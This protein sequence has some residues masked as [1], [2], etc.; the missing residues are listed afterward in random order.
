MI[1]GAE[2]FFF[3]VAAQG[4]HVRVLAEEQDVWDVA[5]FAGFDELILERAG[6]GVGQEACVHLPADFFWVDHE[7]LKRCGGGHS[8]HGALKCAATKATSKANLRQQLPG[9][10]KRD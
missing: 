8:V 3:S 2:I 4:D 9:P 5:G 7:P 6:L 10:K 1:A